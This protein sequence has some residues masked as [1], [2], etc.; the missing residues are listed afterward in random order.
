MP[1]TTNIIRTERINMVYNGHADGMAL[2]QEVAAWCRQSLNPAI[3]DLLAGFA[4]TG[5]V[6]SIP[7][8]NV[9][10]TVNAGQDWKEG[11]IEKILHQVKSEIEACNYPGS[12][13]VTTAGDW[14]AETVT[15]F[16]TAWYSALVFHN[17]FA[18]SFFVRNAYMAA[19]CY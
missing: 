14:F 3:D 1:A 15:F 18:G 10:I 5:E 12:L 16:F 8:I 19:C 11:L 7:S 4:Q 13:Q 17:C 9:D 2:Q 6:I